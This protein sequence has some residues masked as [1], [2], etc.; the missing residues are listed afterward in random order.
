MASESTDIVIYEGPGGTVEVRLDAES[1]WLNQYQ[2]AS[3]FGRE[4][5][6][7]A[8]HIKNVFTDKELDEFSVCA[9]FAQTGADG[10]TYQVEHYNLDLIISIGY[11]VKSTEGVRFRQWATKTLQHHLTRGYTL[12]RQRFEQNA[13]ELEAAL[14]LI[15]KT[16]SSSALT[17]DQGRGDRK[18]VV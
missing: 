16:S 6:V 10:K 17:T 3:L 7:V 14:E 15:R 9:K 2:L 12:H 13:R 8:R 18:S 1:V 5:S 11:R 4:R